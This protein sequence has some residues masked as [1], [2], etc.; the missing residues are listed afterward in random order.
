L[1][2]IKVIEDFRTHHNVENHFVE[3]H[4][5]IQNKEFF[6]SK[7]PMTFFTHVV[8]DWTQMDLGSAEMK[9]QAEG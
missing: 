5:M 7:L 1:K 9:E 2:T 3:S 8:K 6:L 4:N